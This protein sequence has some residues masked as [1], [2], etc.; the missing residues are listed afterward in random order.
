MIQQSLLGIY[1]DKTI[2]KKDTCTL[3][4]YSSTSYNPRHGNNLNIHQQM[5]GW[6]RCGTYIQWNITQPWKEQNNA[7][8]SNMDGSRD[9]HIKWSKSERERGIPYYIT[10]MWNLIYGTNELIYRKEK[11]SWTWRTDLWLPRGKGRDWEGLGV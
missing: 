6:R 5:T 11:N 4:F 7:I 3:M 2:I 10:Y 1:P 9:F 8:C